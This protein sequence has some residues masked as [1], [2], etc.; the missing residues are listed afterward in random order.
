MWVLVVVL[1]DNENRLRVW[2]KADWMVC[3]TC[4][5]SIFWVWVIKNQWLWVSPAITVHTLRKK[6][7][8]KQCQSSQYSL[9][10]WYLDAAWIDIM[11]EVGKYFWCRFL[12]WLYAKRGWWKIAELYRNRVLKGIVRMILWTSKGE[13]GKWKLTEEEELFLG[14]DCSIGC[15]H[16]MGYENEVAPTI[17]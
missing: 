4:N 9:T 2:E 7:E 17:L 10:S 15:I 1:V 8:S 16:K 5:I 13:I 14:K 3:H 6:G 11:F 12:G